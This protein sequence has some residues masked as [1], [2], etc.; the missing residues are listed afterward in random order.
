MATD[1]TSQPTPKTALEARELAVARGGRPVFAGVA[2]SLRGGDALRLAG[3]NGGGKT[4]LLRVL[5]GL[6]SP[7]DGAVLWS[8][9]PIDE[10]REAH[11]RRVAFLAHA[12]ALKPSLTARENTVAALRVAGRSTDAVDAAFAALGIEHLADVPAGWLS[13]GQRRR[14]ALVRVLASDAVLWLLDEPTVGLDAVSVAALEHAIVTHRQ[15]GGI[16]V[17][18]THVALDLGAAA[19][20]LDPAAFSHG[21]RTR[22][23]RA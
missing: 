19:D 18:A 20:N 2:F 1:T 13:A 14:T 8:G 17:A 23:A 16:V 7:L 3:R 11:G 9:R 6:G 10:D 22:G 5:A 21:L 4:S 12:D 15:A